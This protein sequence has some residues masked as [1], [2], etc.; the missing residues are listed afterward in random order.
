MKILF[1]TLTLVSFIF[2]DEVKIEKKSGT[3]DNKDITI[4][5]NSINSINGIKMHGDLNVKSVGDMYNFI[6]GPANLYFKRESDGKFFKITTPVFGF[7]P[8]SSCVDDYL[9]NEIAE[10]RLN[11]PIPFEINKPFNAGHDF[12]EIITIDSSLLK[13]VQLFNFARGYSSHDVYK[14]INTKEEF[15]AKFLYN[16]P[17]NAAVDSKETYGEVEKDQWRLIKRTYKGMSYDSGPKY[18]KDGEWIGYCT[19][20][21]IEEYNYASGILETIIDITTCPN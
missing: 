4:K 19:L 15:R 13:V 6:T 9:S 2:A 8:K 7:K 17:E 10:C 5:L 21:K 14:I 20:E 16:L 3:Y 11:T 1:M 18:N 12:L